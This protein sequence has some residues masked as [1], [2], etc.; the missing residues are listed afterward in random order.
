MVLTPRRVFMA[1][2]AALIAAAAV[3]YL[4]ALPAS[5]AGAAVISSHPVTRTFH[6]TAIHGTNETA[7]TALFLRPDSGFN[8]GNPWALDDFTRT[9]N[10]QRGTLVSGTNCGLIAS[11]VCYQWTASFNDHSGMF[12]TIPGVLSP[13]L[14]DLT[15]LVAERGSF[16][17]TQTETV[18]DTYASAFPGDV[19]VTENDNGTLSGTSS[20]NWP[21]QFFGNA[22]FC[23]APGAST[24]SYHYTVTA[25]A[26]AQCASKL[27]HWTDATAGD[28]AGS[29]DILAPDKAHCAATPST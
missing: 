5:P 6:H 11:H 15:L 9:V 3:L 14:D 4:I 28:V 1:L 20:Q 10:I 18:F 8:S 25:G 26:N 13:G 22:G 24:F 23:H 27:W 7:V 17:G 16:S 29:G 19:P 21:C 2:L 12:Q